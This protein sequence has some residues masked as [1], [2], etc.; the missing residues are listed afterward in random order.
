[1]QKSNFRIRNPD[2]DAESNAFEIRTYA[3]A[4][5]ARKGYAILAYT[6]ISHNQSLPSRRPAQEFGANHYTGNGPGVV[7]SI[8]SILPI[9]GAF[10]SKGL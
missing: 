1:M 4:G 10:A 8:L 7:K 3:I 2:V 5:T 6:P 9:A